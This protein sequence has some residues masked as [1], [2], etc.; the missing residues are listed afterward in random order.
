V[1]LNED[2]LISAVYMQVYTTNKSQTYH[3]ENGRYGKTLTPKEAMHGNP[4]PWC[5]SLLNLYRDAAH[6][7]D[8]AGRIEVRC[9]LEFAE[10]CLTT[11]P[12]DTTRRS[13]TRYRRE[14]WW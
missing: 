3:P 8:V 2:N 4:P 9:P 5:Q 10:G 14:I 11:F 7:V 6:N 13:L 1:I 12:E